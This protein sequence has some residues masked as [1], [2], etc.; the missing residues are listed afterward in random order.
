LVHDWLSRHTAPK[1]L[2]LGTFVLFCTLAVYAYRYAPAWSVL[3]VRLWVDSGL[4]VVI[5]LSLLI[6]RPFTLQYA[7]EE[8]PRSAWNDRAFVRANYLV[9]AVWAAAF[10][11]LVVADLVMLHASKVP[12]AFGIVATVAA[13]FCAVLFT[14][15]ISGPHRPRS[16]L[17]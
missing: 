10:V 2:E 17:T 15:R 16:A 12:R 1:L 4:L 5:L 6:A 13:L 8:A 14:N 9:T 11:V 3:G 7:R